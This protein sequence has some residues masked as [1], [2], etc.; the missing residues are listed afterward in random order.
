MLEEEQQLM[1]SVIEAGDGQ[2]DTWSVLV[3]FFQL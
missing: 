1:A 3:V 2:T